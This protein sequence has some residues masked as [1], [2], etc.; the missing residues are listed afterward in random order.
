MSSEALIQFSKVITADAPQ[1]EE[2]G[3]HVGYSYFT[4]SAD[5]VVALSIIEAAD[6]ELAY[7]AAQSG[8]F[9][10]WES[11]DEDIYTLEDGSPL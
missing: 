4:I 5:I 2:E 9:A 7:L 11:P 6:E 3:T 1:Y 10:F 8:A